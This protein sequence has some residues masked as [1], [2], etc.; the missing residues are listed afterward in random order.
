MTFVLNRSWTWAR[1]AVVLAAAVALLLPFPGHCS[2]CTGGKSECP[3]CRSLGGR[4][5]PGEARLPACCQRKQ[6]TTE[7]KL[8]EPT[9]SDCVQVQSRACNC[10]IKPLDRALATAQER[11]TNSSELSVI[12]PS[13]GV[14]SLLSAG[15][16]DR[17]AVLQ[18][19]LPPP[20]PH[21]I[22]H[23]SWII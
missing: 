6:A 19:D 10:H 22:L 18:T 13:L 3:H 14:A 1:Q 15:E 4:S 17:A 8:A 23:C 11:A 12:L 20:V 16:P 21:R 2:A 9:G 5:L 7:R